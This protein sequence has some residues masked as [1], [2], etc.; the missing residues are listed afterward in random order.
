MW[1]E[2]KLTVLKTD[3][4]DIYEALEAVG[5]NAVKICPRADVEERGIEPP[6]IACN[7]GGTPL[8]WFDSGLGHLAG[9]ERPKTGDRIV[10]WAD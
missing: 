6:F 2:M 10:S 4:R 5:I 7:R 1:R 8:R 3:Y 9:G